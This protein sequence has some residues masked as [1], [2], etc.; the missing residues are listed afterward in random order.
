MKSKGLETESGILQAVWDQ[1]RSL[2]D[3]KLEK[4]GAHPASSIS[5]LSSRSSLSS[6]SSS[7]QG[8]GSGMAIS[9]IGHKHQ[10]YREVARE[11]TLASGSGVHCDLK[12]MQ[13]SGFHRH[14]DRIIFNAQ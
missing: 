4:G 1:I 11:E 7:S 3:D 10:H 2:F 14:W 6:L 12:E 8:M 5:F 13:A 9:H